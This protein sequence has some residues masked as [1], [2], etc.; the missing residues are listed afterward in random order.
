MCVAVEYTCKRAESFLELRIDLDLVSRHHLVRFIRHP[1]DRYH[2]FEH[3]VR[4]AL[5]LRGYG[6]R[7]YTVVALVS[8]ADRHVDEFLGEWV[9]RTRRHDLLDVFPSAPKGGG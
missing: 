5:L 4:H 9:E 7:G 2:L 1:H 6:V 8:Y 3:R